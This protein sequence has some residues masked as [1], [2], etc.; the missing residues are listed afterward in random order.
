MKKIEQNRHGENLFIQVPEIPKGAKLVEEGNKLV[1]AHSE[2]GHNHTL[3]VPKTF[4]I[5]MFE[6]GGITY[7]DVPLEAKL[8]HQKT[9]EAHPD[10]IMKPGF[11][12]KL[13]HRAYSYTEKV[14]KKVID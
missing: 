11:Y 8:Q 3:T 1:V 4:N 6:F 12:K 9:V 14:T 10:Q 2:S 7:L 13:I 5:K